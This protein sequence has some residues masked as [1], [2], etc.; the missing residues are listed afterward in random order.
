MAEMNPEA[1]AEGTAIEAG[2]FSALLEKSFKPKTDRQREAVEE[3]VK[4]L[5]EWALQDTNLITDDALH[6]IEAMVAEIDR[7]LTEQMNLILHHDDFQKLEGSW[8]G[9]S[10][11]VNNTETDE[12]LKIKCA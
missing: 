6:T 9:L 8:R 3:G 12:T 4:T 2:E 10:H 11:L 1:Q 5:A 7:R